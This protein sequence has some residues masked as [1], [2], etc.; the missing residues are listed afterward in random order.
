M[1][2]ALENLEPKPVWKHFAALAGIPR[3]STKEAAARNY[4][5]ALASHLGLKAVQ[6]DAGNV[7]IR[8]PAHAGREQASMALLQGHLDRLKSDKR[9]AG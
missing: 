3:A 7:V 6:D 8:K 2:P 5:L 4:V 1:I 9:R